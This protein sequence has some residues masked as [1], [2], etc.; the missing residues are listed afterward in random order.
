M[1][2]FCG[3]FSCFL[4]CLGEGIRECDAGLKHEVTKG[5]KATAR[6]GRNQRRKHEATK[7]DEGHEEFQISNFTFERF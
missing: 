5:T 1:E 4:A 2:G 3:V 6:Q 7:A